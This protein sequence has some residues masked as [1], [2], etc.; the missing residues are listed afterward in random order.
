MISNV[1]AKW[2]QSINIFSKSHHV[3]V[4]SILIFFDRRQFYM[5]ERFCEARQHLRSTRATPQHNISS[6]QDVG[7]DLCKTKQNFF[8]THLRNQHNH[9]FAQQF[10][11]HRT[12]SPSKPTVEPISCFVLGEYATNT[13]DFNPTKDDGGRYNFGGHFC[14]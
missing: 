14:R 11:S 10:Q 4:A 1:L 2:N 5:G 9:H 13:L 6:P 7:E 3:F 8:R 12:S